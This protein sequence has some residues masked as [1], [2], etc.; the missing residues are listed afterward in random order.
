MQQS[1]FLYA[2]FI[3]PTN[4]RYLANRTCRFSIKVSKKFMN[5]ARPSSAFRQLQQMTIF[6][7]SLSLSGLDGDRVWAKIVMPPPAATTT[8]TPAFDTTIVPGKRVGPITP[9]TTH[10]D[11][12]RIF[13]KQR[14]SAKK[15]Y[16]V[17]GQGEFSATAISLGKNRSIVV[18]WQDNNKRRPV[19]VI[20]EDPSWKTADGIGIGTS[21][22]TL[23]QLLGEFK[24]TGL[25]WD[26]GNQVIGLS[27]AMQARYTGLSISVDADYL[28]GRRY[29]KDLRAV[30]GDRVTLPASNRHWKPLKM[31]VSALSVYFPTTAAPKS[32]KSASAASIEPLK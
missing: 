31:H 28:A 26:Y 27:P 32:K 4:F 12:V 1:I 24:I 30:T 15:V 2:G 18:A 3:I 29:P 11:L 13:G 19:R 22:A 6:A 21:L 8:K 14:L 17:E 9:N 7:A 23:R 20:I 10:A 5:R 16:G 25:Y